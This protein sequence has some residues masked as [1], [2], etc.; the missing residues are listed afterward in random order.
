M[1]LILFLLFVFPSIALSTDKAF[2]ILDAAKSDYIIAEDLHIFKLQEFNSLLLE[3][4][5]NLKQNQNNEIIKWLRENHFVFLGSKFD[6]SFCLNK[7]VKGKNNIPCNSN[8]NPR[9]MQVTSA[10]KSYLLDK[11]FS[12]FFPKITLDKLK[13]DGNFLYSSGKF[14]K[15]NKNSPVIKTEAEVLRKYKYLD[16]DASSLY[17]FAHYMGLM[18][19]KEIFKKGQR[20]YSYCGK[21]FDKELECNKKVT[22][23]FSITGLM[24]YE[25]SKSCFSCDENSKLRLKYYASNYLLRVPGRNDFQILGRKIFNDN[26][27]KFKE[28]MGGEYL[29]LKEIYNWALKTN[30]SAR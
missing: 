19:I 27:D 28:Y 10:V 15:L 21:V 1:R 26:E 18:R 7:K 6:Y 23:S 2:I 3:K 11:N 9:K 14:I 12:L 20:D 25:F 5:F 30:L 4:H 8:Y 16:D 24:L 17:R 29:Y 13:I 22:G